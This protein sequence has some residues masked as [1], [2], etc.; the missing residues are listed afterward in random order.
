M[1]NNITA[2]QVVRIG[3]ILT[4]S[5]VTIDG[6]QGLISQSDI[7]IMMANLGEEK[8]RN[9]DR[10]KLCEVLELRKPI[11]NLY[12]DEKNDSKY[13]YPK[14]YKPITPSEQLNTLRFL[15]PNLDGLNI[16]DIL[17]ALGKVP[18][19]D[20]MYQIVP[21]L[22]TIG[23]LFRIKDPFDSGYGRCLE[24][25]VGHMEKMFPDFTN[26]LESSKANLNAETR[27]Y[28][29]KLE[30]ATKGDFIIISM[31][32]GALYAGYSVRNARIEI[33][34]ANQWALP[35]WIVGHHLLTH[36]KR[37]SENNCLDIDCGGDEYHSYP[38]GGSLF[39]SYNGKLI[40]DYDCVTET[41]AN[42]GSVSGVMR[43]MS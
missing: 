1:S 38:E 27:H 7:L 35:A 12:K 17:R 31:Q 28:L 37:M 21:K 20:E 42:C 32:S 10:D 24:I 39:F 16:P 34:N 11:D 40:L 13:S 9:I 18:P 15:Y 36:T 3:Q 6:A 19:G 22:S 30:L 26:G 43:K 33:M 25:M 23:R 8:L 4:D 2:R 41:Y 29:M 5:E 14:T